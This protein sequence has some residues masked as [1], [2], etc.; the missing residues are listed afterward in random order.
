MRFRFLDSHRFFRR[1]AAVG[2]AATLGMAGA[3]QADTLFKWDEGG[4]GNG[5][6]QSQA[7]TPPPNIPLISHHTA[8]GPVLADDFVPVSTGS[9]TNV[10]WW[11]SATQN[12][13]WE[14]TFHGNSVAND[15]SFP[16]IS[17][18][19]VNAVGS[20]PD[21]DGVFKFTAAWTPMDT[22]LG[23]GNQYWFSVANGSSGWEW[24][25]AGAGGPQVGSEN[26]FALES[27]GGAPS[28]AAGPH[29]GPWGLPTCQACGAAVRTNLA[30]QIDG[31]VPLP[32]SLPLMLAGLAGLFG[33]RRRQKAV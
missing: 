11:G 7:A 13:L 15:P 17:Q 28:V 23:A 22:F 16:F 14:I 9:V 1:F 4:P 26:F 33:L 3:A 19:F 27:R 31:V 10:T 12:D 29:D 8:L 30:F 20:D 5:Q 18:H 21:G 25:L 24:A 6:F 2:F 32:A